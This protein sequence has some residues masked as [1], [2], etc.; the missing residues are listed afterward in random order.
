MAALGAR[1][2]DP[3]KNVDNNYNLVTSWSKSSGRHQIKWGGDIRHLRLDRRTSAGPIFF[4]ERGRFDFNSGVTALRGGPAL[5]AFGAFGNSFASMLL[6]LPD[7]TGRS[8]VAI[9]PSDRMTQIFTYF[10]DT[11]QL[12]RNLTLDLGL[13]YEVYTPIT[14]RLQGGGSNYDPA[15][16]TLLVAGIGDVPMN[17]GVDFD[18]N[19]F[20]PRVGIAYRMN[21]RTVIRA[22]YGLSYFLGRFGFTGG[23]FGTQFPAVL[24]NQVGVANDFVP[25]G[26]INAVP[27]VERPAIP[28]NGRISPAPDQPLFAIP[29]DYP[30]PF[31]HSY[32]FTVQHEIGHG[33]RLDAGYVGSLG[34]Q[35][36]YSLPLNLARPGEGAAGRELFRRYGRTADTTLRAT[37]IRNNY[38]SLQVGAVKRFQQGLS[39]TAAYTWSKALGVGDDQGSFTNA[40]DIGANYGVTSYDRRHMLTVSHVYELP[41]GP[42]KRLANDGWVSYLARGWQLSGILRA[43]SGTRF[44]ALADSTPCN[45]P[46]NGNYADALRPVE[47]LKGAGPGQL[48][49]TTSSFG[50]PGPNRFGTAGRN[51]V[52]GP[53]I[54]NYDVSIFRN[55]AVRERMRLE[56]RAE[57]YNVSNTPH[58]S[59]PVNNVN[60]GNFGQITASSGEREVQLALRLT[61]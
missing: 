29:S 17:M 38:N 20:A 35:L 24:H 9:T 58:F 1:P 18:P 13:R 34:R 33:I 44:S 55:F 59:N 16:N 56:L 60:A 61:F 30:V 3:L 26:T 5:G 4:S 19:N 23:T 11:W 10:Q 53:G 12:T 21:D 41:F 27:G 39:F 43:A 2:Q 32:S 52:L 48:W 8:E 45:C 57:F 51:T 49:F 14:P 7:L 37:G 50:Q 36:P 47:L 22:G 28:S 40:V 42:G 31:V 6:G 25:A 54:V 15:T 46:G